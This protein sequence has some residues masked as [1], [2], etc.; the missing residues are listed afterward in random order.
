[1]RNKK[2][3][4]FLLLVV[5]IIYTNSLFAG[6][7]WDD[8]ALVVKKQLFFSR[9]ENA[10]KILAACDA[11]LGGKYPYYRPLNTLTYMMDHY[12][13]GVHPLWYHV[14]NLLL[15]ALVVILF[16]FLL[17][18]AFNDKRLAFIAS[19]L[20]AVYPTNTEA[21]DA[22]FNRNMLLCAVF[23]ISSLLFLANGGRKWTALSFLA[24][25]LG[26][27]SKEPAV[28]LPFFLLS[29]SLT[30]REKGLR[31]SWKVLAGFFTLTVFYFII[32]R[33]VLGAF[34]A[35]T[36]ISFSLS[37]VKLILSVYFAH[38]RLM[39][40]P[41]RLNALYT[42]K[43]VSFSAFKAATA[44]SGVLLLVY[45]SLGRKIPDPV[46]AGA[47]WIFWGLLPVSN[48]VKIPSAPVADRYQYMILFG[49]VLMLGYLVR[50]F[51]KEKAVP[52]I[53]LTAA[54][55]AAFGVRTFER[56]PVWRDNISLYSSMIR[57]DT[58]NAVAYSN[59][60]DIYARR[61]DLAA[62]IRDAKMALLLNPS[63]V[64]ARLNLGM[65]YAKQG[66]VD[67]AIKE[68][69]EILSAVPGHILARM[70]LGLAYME[71]GQFPDAVIQ[72][73]TVIGLDPTVT[74][75]HLFLGISYEKEGFLKDA[76]SEFQQVLALEP[77]N[78]LA[79]EQI[80]EIEHT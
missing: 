61:G 77:G 17:I 1:M 73:R 31:V 55:A 80:A 21:V 54:L 53:A 20:F 47:Q 76:M 74:G 35:N 3:I 58:G 69:K 63:M 43:T 44:I 64:S 27:L 18:E 39:F 28:V 66:R 16:Y 11:P 2:V 24:Y 5:G 72:F 65:A 6:F 13:W 50:A 25:F 60:S 40:F 49:F 26:L 37:R 14:E 56:N 41:F 15:H 59:L 45:L 48:I 51:T 22:V 78:A 10:F 30:S 8:R 23:S 46:K 75:A 68:F 7:V 33:L 70:D 57:A 62:A 36:G 67:E 71:K 32:R 9:P 34:I 38:F 79:L 52:A 29:F 19:L 42:Q 4:I 12:L